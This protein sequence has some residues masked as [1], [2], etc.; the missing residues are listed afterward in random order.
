MTAP[1]TYSGS[2][3]SEK[4]QPLAGHRVADERVGRGQADREVEH[5]RERR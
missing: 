5:Q 4:M 3:R 1:G 2:C